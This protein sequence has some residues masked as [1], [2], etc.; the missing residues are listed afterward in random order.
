MKTITY[1]IIIFLIFFIVIGNSCKKDSENIS[2]VTTFDV[3]TLKGDSVVVLLLGQNFIDS[4][5]VSSGSNPVTET[6]NININSVGTYSVVYSTANKDGFSSSITRTIY[7]VY[8]FGPDLSGTYKGT[9][10][11]YSSGTV[12]ISKV[13]NGQYYGSDLLAGAY[14]PLVVPF[15]MYYYNANSL[16]LLYAPQ[17]SYGTLTVSG[18]FN[19]STTGAI[20]YSVT[21]ASNGESLGNFQ[22]VK[23]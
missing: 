20:T 12:T 10:D 14:L 6:N 7:V 5:A 11:G 9:I 22:L 15:Y 3:L 16:L 18:Y 21:N 19:L 17:T 8:A 13:N 4:G 1:S 23:Q 2:K